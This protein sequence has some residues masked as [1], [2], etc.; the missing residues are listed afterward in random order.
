MS[1]T[2]IIEDQF[3][4][5]EDEMMD[6]KPR[7]RIEMLKER[8]KLLGLKH[9]P[10][11]GEEALAKKIQDHLEGTQGLADTEEVAQAAVQEEQG[12]PALTVEDLRASARK[13]AQKLI[14]VNIVPNDPQRAQLQG[15]LIYTGNNQIGT[16]GKYVP[17]GTVQGYH[18]PQMI[19]D[20]LKARTY[21]HFM[22][23]KDQYKNEVAYPIQ[24]PAYNIE[25]LP[26][27]TEKEIKRIADRQAMAR[28]HEAEMREVEGL[29]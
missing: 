15:E 1:K 4:D 20:I 26:N 24:R 6:V 7:P 25:I 9:S 22:M 10:N 17:Y 21:T 3:E 11:I 14:R 23:R 28:R 27:L 13:N 16:I 18:I 29:S 2:D 8:A 12:A 19:Y 5:D